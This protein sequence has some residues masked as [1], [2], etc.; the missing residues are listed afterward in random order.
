MAR[1]VDNIVSS[2]IGMLVLQ[3]STLI[4]ENETLKEQLLKLQEAKVAHEAST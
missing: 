1:T 3:I 4:A 2:Q